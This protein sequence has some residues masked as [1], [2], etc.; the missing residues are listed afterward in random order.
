MLQGHPAVRRVQLV[1]SRQRGEPNVLSDWDFLVETDDPGGLRR[2]LPGVVRD[3]TPIAAQWD[4]LSERWSY[5]LILRGGVKV[6]IEL[7]GTK[8]DDEPPW[9]MSLQTLPGIDLHFWDWILWL[10]SKVLKGDDEFIRKELEKLSEHLLQPM[11]VRDVPGSIAAAVSAY[12]DARDAAEQS[13][14]IAVSR[15]LENEVRHALERGGINL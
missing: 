12:S 11:G 13:L 15:D 4:R 14:G 5:M 10:G 6:D 9:E 2:E 7:V 3:L 8:Q 1:G